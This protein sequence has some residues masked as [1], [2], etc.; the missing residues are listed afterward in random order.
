MRPIMLAAVTALA[1]IAAAVAPPADAADGGLIEALRGNGAEVT[2]LGSR[3]G[4]QG[5]LV[6]PARGTG[7]SLYLTEDGHAVAGLLYGPDGVEVTGEQLARAGGGE[8]SAD[9]RGAGPHDT[10]GAPVATAHATVENSGAEASP[11]RAGL[12]ERSLA[13]FGF[14]L[15]ERGTAVVLF[16]DPT[17]RWS[18]SAAARLGREALAGRLQLRVVPVAVLGAAAAREALA[19]AA[20]PDPAF[21]WFEGTSGPADPRA[22]DTRAARPA[23]RRTDRPQQRA[24][25]GVGRERRAVDRLADAR[26]CGRAPRRRHRRRRRL[27]ERDTRAGDGP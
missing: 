13:A 11:G 8:A 15:G 17:C 2:A 16:A 26:R 5:Y 4:L 21:A 23:W 25:R 12:F 7:Y 14:T 27:A 9:G 6:T 20:H 18:R 24:L 19:I 3:G 1:A 10:G 22:G